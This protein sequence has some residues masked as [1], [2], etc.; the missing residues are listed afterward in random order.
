MTKNKTIAKK[1]QKT[2]AANR[3]ALCRY[4]GLDTAADNLV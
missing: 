4:D 3:K 1:K 2:V